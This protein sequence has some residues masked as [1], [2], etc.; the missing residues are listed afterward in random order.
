MIE[1]PNKNPHHNIIVPP[2]HQYRQ[3]LMT[4]RN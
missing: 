3:D 1:H 4:I 2:S